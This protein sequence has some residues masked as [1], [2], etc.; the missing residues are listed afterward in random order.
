MQ[1]NNNELVLVTG[2]NGFVGS[3]VVKKLIDEG[4]RVRATIRS[5]KD[6]KKA[7][8]LRDLAKNSKHELELA[9]ADLLNEQSWIN[10]V[11]G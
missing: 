3:H 2:A 5:L 4:Y 11:K 10:A 9:E 1:N 6:E 7:Q 8:P